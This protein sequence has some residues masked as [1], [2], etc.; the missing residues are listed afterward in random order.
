MQLHNH[1]FSAGSRQWMGRSFATAELAIALHQS[2]EAN[3]LRGR[4]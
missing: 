1:P 4:E 3:M 2:A